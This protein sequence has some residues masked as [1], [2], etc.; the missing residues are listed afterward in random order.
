MKLYG[1]NA[2]TFL[3]FNEING[4]EEKLKKLL[5]WISADRYLANTGP[6]YGPVSPP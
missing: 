4:D 3:F 1:E 5:A 2:F 6:G